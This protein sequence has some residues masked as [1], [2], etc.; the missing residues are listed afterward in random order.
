MHPHAVHDQASHPLSDML[1]RFLPLNWFEKEDQK[2]LFRARITVAITLMYCLS[3]LSIAVALG[4]S[5]YLQALVWWDATLSCAL[6]SGLYLCQILYFKKTG[7]LQTAAAMTMTIMLVFTSRFIYITGGWHSP[8]MLFL[9]IIPMCGFLITGHKQGALWSMLCVAVYG[10]LG[11]MEYVGIVAPQTTVQGYEKWLQFCTWIFSW[12]MIVA[13]VLLYA[14]MVNSLNSTINIEKEKMRLFATIDEESGAYS[15]KA[16]ERLLAEKIQQPNTAIQSQGLVFMEL[17]R[18]S[19]D[20]QAARRQLILG[21]LVHGTKRKF[22]GQAE[23][24]RYGNISM[25]L[26]V[27]SAKDLAGIQQEMDEFYRELQ[28]ELI[29]QGVVLCM[30]GVL[31]PASF[32]DVQGMMDEA[33]KALQHAKTQPQPKMFYRR[34]KRKQ[35]DQVPHASGATVTYDQI[36]RRS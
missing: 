23:I 2:Q 26:W 18:T 6:S 21:M 25:T 8:V 30:G 32:T 15:R 20:L 28:Q 3:L 17:L 27:Q 4:V 22:G 11:L 34:G 35:Q 16:F 10:G 1:D 33:R 12:F 14:S 7:N 24:S 9:F 19:G 31:V 36:I 5:A 13:G 29:S